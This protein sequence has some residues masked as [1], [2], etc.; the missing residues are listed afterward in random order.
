MMKYLIQNGTV[1]DGTGK[2]P[3]QAD[4]L[5]SGDR[6]VSV[7]PGLNV[8]DAKAVD[9]RG[10]AV[11][12]GFIDIH[13][14]CDFRPMADPD[15][16][17]VELAQGITTT[18]A[19]NCGLAPV[20]APA[21]FRQEMYDFIEPC[22]GVPAPGT[23]FADYHAYSCAVGSS[24]LNMNMGFLAGT[25]AVKT[26][27]KGYG[28]E[29]YTPEE[30]QRAVG[31]AEEAMNVGAF[32]VSMGIM[33]QPECYS[34]V[35]ELV[36]LVRPA[37][38]HGGVLC[39]HI[40]GE[41]DSLV[42]SV[43]EIIS[44]AG[45]AGIRL[46]ISHFKSTG[47]KNWN[48]KIYEAIGAV[49]Q[50][51]SK[52]QDVM[53]DFYPYTGGSTTLLTLLPPCVLEKTQALTL[54]KLSTEAGKK[55]LREQIYRTHPGWDNMVTG[56]GWKNIL[57]S[58]LEN[59][60]HA[61]FQGKNVEELAAQNGYADPSDFACD[62][63]VSEKGKVG[64]I[65]LSMDQNDVDTVARLPYSMVISDSLYGG[66]GSPHPRLYGSFA[67]IVREYVLERRVLTL[68]QA[69]RKMTSMPAERMRLD[70]RGTIAPGN[71]AD[72]N[73]FDPREFRDN[74]VYS[75]PKQLSTGMQWVF[76]NG[77]PVWHDGSL[78]ARGNGRFLKRN[79]L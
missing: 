28:K 68:E 6:I 19:G 3:K 22:L 76:L 33:Y 60:E 35:E 27:V 72:I 5:V 78:E 16:G 4:V 8:P 44:I 59:P 73:I 31:Y 48:K 54:Q 62:L 51:R 32:G 45:R 24:A 29:P 53:V 74:A 21:R 12:P 7:E 65:V 49:E 34:S 67:K 39:C 37:A 23:D 55:E 14:H 69:V 1:Y 75:D 52:G 25:G 2:A 63:L 43:R 46:N 26:A 64:I 47:I 38:K 17:K 20:P 79:S 57:I 13:R 77:V 30:M 66:G 42:E 10:K 36:S 41:G 58:S 15:F 61:A 56:I 11:A 50:A 71:Y 9:A 70:G 18:I 40:R